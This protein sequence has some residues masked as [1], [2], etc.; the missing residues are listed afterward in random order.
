[1]YKV[2]LLRTRIFGAIGD[3]QGDFSKR[4]YNGFNNTRSTAE[5]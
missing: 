4:I 5:G 3:Q 2:K 1:M